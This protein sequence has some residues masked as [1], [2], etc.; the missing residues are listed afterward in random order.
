MQGNLDSFVFVRFLSVFYKGIDKIVFFDKSVLVW[1]CNNFDM[2]LV[3][4]GRFYVL[5]Q[6]GIRLGFSYELFILDIWC[7]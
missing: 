5:S 1:W 3:L 2:Y 7:N 6:V 4:L